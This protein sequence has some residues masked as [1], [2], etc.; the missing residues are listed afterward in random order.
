MKKTLNIIYILLFLTILLIP[1]LL[2]NREEGVISEID[3]RELLEA[4]IFGEEGY[5]KDFEAYLQDRIGLRSQM[6]NSY[7][8]LNDIVADELTHPMYTYGQAGYIF[9]NMH[10]TIPYSDFHKKFAEAVLKMQEYCESRG[11]NFY[12]MFEPEKN[13]VLRSYLPEGVNYDNAWVDEMLAYMDELGINYVSNKD[14]LAEKS[15]DEIVFNRQF[16][17]GHWNDLGRFYGTNNLLN[18]IHEDIPTVTPLT[19][20]QFI[21]TTKTATQ[22][23]VSEFKINEEVPSFELK[24]DYKD[25]TNN[26][27]DDVEFNSRYPYF[28]YHINKAEV[29]EELPKTLFFQG[30]YYNQSP[31]FMISRTSEYIG[32]HNYQNVLN[33]DYY[34]NMFQ[35]DLVIFEVAEYT[36]SNRYFDSA[37]MAT[38]DFNP[39]IIDYSSNSSFKDQVNELKLH[40]SRFT[41]DSILELLEGDKVDNVL[42]DRRF[43]D[44]QYSYLLT[45]D[46]VIDLKTN[47]EGLLYANL[48][49]G[50]IADGDN[51]TVYIE[52]YDGKKIYVPLKA[53]SA[54][55]FTDKLLASEGTKLS[56]DTYTLTT[57]I[58]GNKFNQIVLQ[59]YN[60]ETGEYINS[61]N[62][63][64]QVGAVQGT[65]IHTGQSGW[66]TLRLKVN[67]NLQ[68]EYVDCLAHLV[69]GSKYY[70]SFSV[71]SLSEQEAN[72]SNFEVYGYRK[73]NN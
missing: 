30:S 67:S 10:D 59:L 19:K 1:L 2:T 13:S 20:E 27:A 28:H 34:Y 26:Y 71:N 51:V 64:D 50:E 47:D 52:E 63:T 14:L 15:Y 61:L 40:A 60:A 12:F 33:L 24:T 39:A 7:A 38:L 21:I 70:Y 36:F 35:P 23:P 5:A 29:A 9:A 58:V 56:G 3:N 31:Q 62:S 48:P 44:A 42:V 53:I 17:A 57:D 25:V 46:L 18:R 43:S 16:D 66:Y 49:H 68:D 22:L 32:I 8:V 69:N 11:S 54:E 6:V 73:I 37:K 55:V 41:V 4:P 45:D 72:L 65:Y